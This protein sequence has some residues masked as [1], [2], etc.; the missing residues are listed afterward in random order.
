[1]S[2]SLS[3]DLRVRVV[4]AVA[5]GSSHRAAAAR[6]GVSAASV[7]RWRRRARLEGDPGPRAVG[8][9]RRSGR[10]E[11]YSGLI[12]GV[13]SETPDVTIEELRRLLAGR[14]L[15][16]GYGTVQRFLVRHNM[17]RKKKTGHASEQDRP[18]VLARRQA[19]RD[20]QNRL[21]A[22]R[23]VFIDGEA[24]RGRRPRKPP[25]GAKTNMARSHG[26][27]PRGQ[28][29]SMGQPHGHW[30]T[31]TFVAGLTLRGM[32]APFVLDRPINR[33]AFETYV[34]KVL[35]PELRPGDI[36]IMDNLSSHKGA[37]VRQSIEAAGAELRFL[38]PYSPDLNPIEMAFAKLKALL[39]KAGERTV[40]GLWGAIARILDTFQP[41]EYRNYFA[42]AGYDPT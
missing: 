26:R 21:D 32:I 23:L 8:G 11:A 19:W 29:L 41:Q 3:L 34:E 31:S 14:G 15:C 25:N 18:D 7:S 5:A 17:T 39:R 40:D 27:A 36:V 22:A 24:D 16:F 42:A 9:D 1:M 2:R 13:L 33:V 35:V 10:I 38:P 28:R 12:L 30:K 20:G 37:G 6:Y 4:A